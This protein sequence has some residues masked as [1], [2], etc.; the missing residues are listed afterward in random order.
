MRSQL[1]D[2]LEYL[3]LTIADQLGLSVAGLEQLIKTMRTGARYPPSTF[4]IYYETA[5]ALMIEQESSDIEPLFQELLQEQPLTGDEVRVVTLDMVTP[6]SNRLLYQR[7]MDTDPNTPFHICSPD[8]DTTD[9]AMARFNS[10]MR[11]LQQA[12]PELAREFEALV[13]EVILVVGEEGLGYG[14]AGGSCY[15]LWGALFIN[16]ELHADD[17]AVIEA[18]A[19]ESGHS[20]LFGLTIDEPLVLNDDEELFTSPLRDDPRPMDGI[21]HATYVSARMHWAMSRLLE[22]KQLNGQERDLASA[23]R[24]ASRRSFW[25]GYQTVHQFARLSGT[26]RILMDGAH[27]YMKPFAVA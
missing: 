2:S 25:N 27:D 8:P 20:F 26:G 1:A 17:I 4:G 7:L 3:Q 10:G 19:H 22:G 18:I 16:A 21:Y 5:A 14:F 6:P 15:M 11:R 9:N 23:K 24:E 12:I 13:R